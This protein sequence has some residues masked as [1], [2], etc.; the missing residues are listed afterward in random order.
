MDRELEVTPEDDG[1]RL[2]RLLADKLEKFSRTGLQRLIQD[3][4]ILVN[5]RKVTP[6]FAVSAGD[7]ISLDIADA[8]PQHRTAALKPRPD[9][10]LNIVHEDADVAVINKP[11]GLL[12]H[13]SVRGEEETLAAALIARHPEMAGVG[14]S[15]ERP[16]IMHRLD[17]DASGLLV[18][19]KTKKAY[20]S[21]KR[22]FQKHAVKKEY[23]V[24]VHGRPPKDEGTITLAVGRASSGDKMA[25][26]AEPL[27]G[28]RSAVTHYRIDEFYAGASLLTVRTETGRTHQI[29]AHFKALGCPVAGD[30]LYRMKRGPALP[31]GRLFL[32]CK[33]LAFTHPA[34]RRKMEFT[35]PLPADLEKTL[36]SLRKDARH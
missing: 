19:A 22:Q 26:R 6:H 12:V 15:W 4:R 36:S 18:V 32:H 35:A 11:S 1:R 23:A 9:I 31:A 13:P 28:D 3:G 30:P 34:S 33:T 10:A 17:K 16:G 29:R 20:G 27:A 21:L 24:L 25:A 5:G 7:R 2:D 8:E 14:E